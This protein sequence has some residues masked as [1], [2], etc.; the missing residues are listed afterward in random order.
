MDYYRDVFSHRPYLQSFDSNSV[1][2]PSFVIDLEALER[3][4][5]IL[6]NVQEKSGARILLA[7][8]GFA[9]F[10]TFSQLKGKLKGCC[11]SSPHEARLARE[12]FGGEVHAFAPAFSEADMAENV[13]LCDHIVFNSFNQWQMH[14]DTVANSGRT[15]SCGLRV[16]PEH[17]ETEVEIYNPCAKGSRLGIRRE[18]FEGQDLSGIEGLHF[19]TLCQQGAEALERTALAFEEKFADLLP[20]MKWLNFGGGHHITQPDYNVDKLCE[21]IIYFKEKYDL[22]VYLEPGEAVGI[23]T[24]SLIA[25]VLEIIDGDLPVAILDTSATCHMPDVLEMPYRPEVRGAALPNEK[26]Y[27]YKLGGLSCLAGDV[28]GDY[29][30]DEPL[31]IGQRIILD[32]M[33]H[34][35]MVK[36]T[37][38]NGIK[39][40]S[41]VL[42][43]QENDSVDIVK[44]F[45]YEDYR[46]RLS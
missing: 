14:K 31:S 46:S 3:N 12:E 11:A 23:N 45:T 2:S 38:F 41:I 1:P 36:T 22:E 10:S 13:Q 16:N 8:K 9:T 28:I 37:T 25:T 21:L 7:L 26:A 44:N 33:T 24:G 18:Q 27:T 29:S 39:L 34:Y 42:Y 4:L 35:T 15:I 30:F 40:P 19:H 6:C 17:S 43:N 20:Q 5:D 32:D